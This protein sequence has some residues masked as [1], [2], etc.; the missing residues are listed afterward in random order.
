MSA[1]ATSPTHRGGVCSAGYRSL[2]TLLLGFAMLPGVAGASTPPSPGTER[3]LVTLRETKAELPQ[4]EALGA[5]LRRTFPEIGVLALEM[6]RGGVEQ[7][8]RDPR[9]LLVEPDPWRRP[10]SALQ[11]AELKPLAT[12]G[13]YGL[14]TTKVTKAHSRSIGADVTVCVADSGIDAEHPDIAPAYRGGIDTVDDDDNPDVG[15]DGVLGGHGTHVAGTIV[16]ALNGQGV[17]GVAFGAELFFAR[18]L[19]EEGGSSS[20]VMAGVRHLVQERG[21]RI[22]NLSLGG[23]S[24]AV[25]EERF[26]EEMRAIHG[27]LIV[28]AAGNENEAVIFPAAYRSVVAVAAVDKANKRASFSNFGPEIDLAAPG[29]GVLSSVPRGSSAE[30][31]LVVGSRT[32]P[33]QPMTFAGH[34]DGIA[35]TLVNCGSGNSAAEFPASVAGNLALIR[36]GV[37]FFSVKVQHAMDAGALGAVIF[38]NVAGDFGGTLQEATA[39]GGA[40]WIPALSVSD[41]NGSLLLRQTGKKAT[42]VSIADDWAL[43]SGTSMATPHVSGVAALV[44]AVQP[45]LGPDDVESILKSTAKDL[46]TRGADRFFGAGLVD[47]DAATRAAARR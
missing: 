35:A 6:P 43:F 17:R 42:L 20:D 38:N 22:V 23:G 13:L 12:N 8:R 15:A 9:V 10:L 47:A 27:A 45:A 32:F 29:V 31:R 34:T 18:V 44:L 5:R 4:L 40:D 19:G 2:G 24:P 1:A 46:G 39:A 30:A 11:G 28:A 36:R 37:E 14:V 26:Y 3:V 7:L 16:A 41:T 21:C 25:A 33:A